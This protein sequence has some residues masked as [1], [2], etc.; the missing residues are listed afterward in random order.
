[1]DGIVSIL[2]L[3]K[4]DEIKISLVEL[5][6]DRFPAVDDDTGEPLV[7]MSFP[8]PHQNHAVTELGFILLEE[9]KLGEVE[10]VNAWVDEQFLLALHR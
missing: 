1:M 2:D 4:S 6:C 3:V 5:I 7:L 9:L 10:E 8:C